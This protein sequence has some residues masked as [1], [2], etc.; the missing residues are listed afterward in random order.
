M[1]DKAVDK[2][3]FVFDSVP[4]QY[5]TQEMCNK[6]LSEDPLKLK[7]CH[8]RY[9]T[10]EVC[11]KA[12]DDFLPTLK[13]VPGLFVMNK[14]IKNLHTAL[15]ADDS[16]LY[17]NKD[18]DNAIFSFNVI[19]IVITDLNNINLHNTNY[20]AD[21]PENIVHIRLLA[22]HNEFEKQRALKE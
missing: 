3:P 14:M 20:D 21:Q 8:D 16:I 9:K 19:G 13:F 22:W 15:Y 1:C 7:Y 10:Q 18:S 17:F 4:N 2:C 11:N 6:N 5:K 12:V